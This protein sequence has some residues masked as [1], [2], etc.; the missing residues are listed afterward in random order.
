MEFWTIS[1]DFAMVA[2]DILPLKRTD[3]IVVSHLLF[4][5]DMLVFC[6]GNRKS[7]IGLNKALYNLQ[8]FTRLTINEQKCKAFYSKG[9]RVKEDISDILGVQSGCL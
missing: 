9:Y 7:A 2:G 1:L 6:K 3:S 5:D 8:L 4:T